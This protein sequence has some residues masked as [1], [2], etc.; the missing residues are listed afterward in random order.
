MNAIVNQL[1]VDMTPEQEDAMQQM[2]INSHY[3]KNTGKFND[4]YDGEGKIRKDYLEFKDAYIGNLM[5][6]YRQN[7]T[8]LKED[9]GAGRWY[10]SIGGGS[11]EEKKAVGPL[12]N[13][14]F[15]MG[16]DYQPGIGT[17]ILAI[18]NPD[19]TYEKV[20]TNAGTYPVTDEPL[21]SYAIHIGD[22]INNITTGNRALSAH[23][24]PIKIP[25]DLKL[26]AL[27]STPSKFVVLPKTGSTAK[28]TIWQEKWTVNKNG[29]FLHKDGSFFKPQEMQAYAYVNIALTADDLKNHPELGDAVSLTGPNTFNKM[30]KV[31]YH[32]SHTKSGLTQDGWRNVVSK[33]HTSIVDAEDW[34]F[35]LGDIKDMEIPVIGSS[36]KTT[37]GKKYPSSKFDDIYIATIMVPVNSALGLE[38]GKKGSK[39][40]TTFNNNNNVVEKAQSAKI[41]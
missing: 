12:E 27:I 10:D 31:P 37:L 20:N 11:T 32:Y 16:E 22:N 14:A 38:E 1:A 30:A 39:Y 28:Q 21:Q 40:A 35:G 19:G 33:G 4:I 9:T 26:G 29:D 41:N 17:Q 2:Y 23:G 3:D 36:E 8:R 25:D 34:G 24:I 13:I 7:Q 6:N 5:T 18:P 15:N